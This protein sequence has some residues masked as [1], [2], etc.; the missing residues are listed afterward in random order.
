MSDTAG[1]RDDAHCPTDW[2]ALRSN[3]SRWL[4]YRVSLLLPTTRYAKYASTAPQ[5]QHAGGLVKAL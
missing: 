4:R 1:S 5:R 2:T 3:S